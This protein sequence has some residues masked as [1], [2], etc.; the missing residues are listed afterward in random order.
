M[1]EV[2][3]DNKTTENYFHKLRCETVNY[4][5]K[6]I[7]I[8][9]NSY[10]PFIVNIIKNRRKIRNKTLEMKKNYGYYLNR[11]IIEFKRMRDLDKELYKTNI[12]KCFKSQ[13]DIAK[14]LQS[15]VNEIS[16]KINELKSKSEIK[17]EIKEKKDEDKD[18]DK[19]NDQNINKINVN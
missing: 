18:K 16:S 17:N 19:N 14:D 4:D 10:Q 15:E 12:I 6:L 1:K 7:K 11:A 5:N 8:L 9:K 13:F 2:L 3:N